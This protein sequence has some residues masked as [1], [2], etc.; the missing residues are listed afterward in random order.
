LKKPYTVGGL[1]SGVG[2]IEQGFINNDFKVLWSNDIDE[3]SSK[4]FKQNFDHQHILQD[5]HTLKGKDLNPIDVLVGGFPCQAFS[6]A[7]YRKG[8][9]DNRGN[10][11]F[12]ILRLVKE[13]KEKPKVLFLENVKNFYTHDHGNTFATVHKELEKNGYCVFHKVL[14]TSSITKVP[15]NRERTFIICFDEGAGAKLDPSQKMT[16][17]FIQIFPPKEIKKTDSIR[18]YLEKKEVE[19]RFFYGEEKYMYKELKDTIKSKD[20]VYQWRRQYVRENKSNVCP[21]LTANMGTGGHNVPLIMNDDGRYRKLTPRECFNLQGFPKSYKLP[22]D[23]PV[24]Q[25]YKQ[26][27]NSVTVRIIEV[28]AGLVKEAMDA[29]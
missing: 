21:T 11:F 2:G 28:L 16:Q 5:I 18:K 20:T 10:L 3:P 22:N 14:N 23:I 15:Q 13:L 1:F 7:G 25:L 26:A 29:K 27:G 19:D 12:E 6:I 24:S 17:K 8:F 9:D 4:T